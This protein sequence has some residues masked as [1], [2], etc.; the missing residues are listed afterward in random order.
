MF[1]SAHSLQR[2]HAESSDTESLHTHGI[3]H[4]LHF[5]QKNTTWCSL[6]LIVS[7]PKSH[8]ST[9][10]TPDYRR[11]QEKNST[12]FFCRWR[13]VTLLI[14]PR[15]LA[16]G[17]HVTLQ[18]PKWVPHASIHDHLLNLSP[19]GRKT[20]VVRWQSASTWRNVKK[21]KVNQLA[22]CTT[23]SVGRGQLQ[24]YHSKQLPREI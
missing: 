7:R 1:G 23:G 14:V 9:I 3:V 5:R 6:L 10:V 21:T 17:P 13:K 16:P 24:A 8:G 2:V 12:Q 22:D 19:C 18:P 15:A 11:T 20:W 4:G